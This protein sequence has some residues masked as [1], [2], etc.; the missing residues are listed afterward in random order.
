[1]KNSEN[2]EKLLGKKH[3]NL[4]RRSKAI[5]ND[6]LTIDKKSKVKTKITKTTKASKRESEEHGSDILRL[7]RKAVITAKMCYRLGVNFKLFQSK[8]FLE[9][10]VN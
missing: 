5:G 6:Q 7:R 4:L 2:N 3:E 8:I 1:M 10:S 9:Q